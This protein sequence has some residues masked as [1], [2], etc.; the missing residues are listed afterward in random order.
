MKA[1]V[2]TNPTE[3]TYRDEPEPVPEVGEA[4]IKVDAAGICGSDMHAF[5][6]HDE[7]RYPPLILGH[8]VS[9]V[10][11]GGSRDG[12]A[13]V[14]NPLM[15]CGTCDACLDGR[16][17][18][19][20]NRQII[21]M[22]PRE[23]AFAQYL[24]M[25]ERN[26]VSMPQRMNPVHAA[27]AEPVATA[28]HA[29]AVATRASARPVAE[30]K[31]LVLGAGAVGLAVGLVL[32]LGGCRKIRIGDTNEFRRATAK[33]AGCGDVYDP[34]G[35][36]APEPNGYDIVIDAVGGKVTR[37]V[38]VAAAKPGGVIVHIGLMDNDGGLDIRKITLQEIS[39]IGTY[40][41]TMVDFRATVAA[42]HSGAL[43]DLAWVEARPLAEGHSAFLDLDAGRTPAAKIVLVPD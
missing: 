17:N 28:W 41:Y 6:G 16:S 43:G 27:A 30:C 38:A 23:G 32:H 10:I 39:F 8:E 20:A 36:P 2:Y 21:G 9:G 13:V 11:V 33:V 7:R 18:L 4:L 15:T 37:G 40:T 25:P 29:V 19:C 22:N 24:R 3:L 35:D 26:L 34:I 12:E 31:A 1:L 42:L 5:H 14:V